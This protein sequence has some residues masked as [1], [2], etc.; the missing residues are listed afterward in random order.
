VHDIYWSQVN[1]LDSKRSL[2]VNIILHQF[3]VTPS[4]LVDALRSAL[5]RS[6]LTAAD[7]ADSPVSV[8]VE[9]SLE[10]LR[11]LQRVLPESDDIDALRTFDGDTSRL[12]SA[13]KFYLQL[14]QLPQ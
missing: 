10:R 12:G 1:L 8:K 3:R 2:N 11:G 5:P 6:Q 7:A 4:E 9:L 13:E 14:I